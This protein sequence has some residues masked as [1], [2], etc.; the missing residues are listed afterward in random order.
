MKVTAKT[1]NVNQFKNCDVTQMPIEG[2]VVIVTGFTN[3]SSCCGF[4]SAV[5]YG[6][7]FSSQDV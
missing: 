6:T 5:V 3:A 4:S 7:L 1:T 2:G